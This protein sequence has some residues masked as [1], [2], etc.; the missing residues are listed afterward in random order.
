MQ[1]AEVRKEDR[2]S[3]HRFEMDLIGR[4]TWSTV[5]WPKTRMHLVGDRSLMHPVYSRLYELAQ[6]YF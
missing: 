4:I 6:N 3:Y 5:D 1:L 2:D